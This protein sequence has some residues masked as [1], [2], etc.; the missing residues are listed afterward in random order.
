V[1]EAAIEAVEVTEY[2]VGLAVVEGPGSD[3]VISVVSKA[4]AKVGIVN[5]SVAM[6]GYPTMLA[7]ATK[8]MTSTCDGVIGLHIVERDAIGSGNGSN[9]AVLM[10]ALY[11]VGTVTDKPVI[12]GIICQSSLLEAKGVLPNLAKEW[13]GAML[14]MVTLSQTEDA[15][16]GAEKAP[17][18]EPY[19]PPTPDESNYTV[20]LDKFRETLK[21]LCC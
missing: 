18:A 21:V 9:S 4:L 5:I 19:A 15:E 8:K 2:K 17:E 1:N 20:L 14:E 11:E 7:Q 6:V 12:P 3:V 13:C 10:S 16:F